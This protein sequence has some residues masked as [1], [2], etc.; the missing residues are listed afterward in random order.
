MPPAQEGPSSGRIRKPAVCREPR[1]SGA[2]T[3]EPGAF[4]LWGVLVIDRQALVAQVRAHEGCVLHAYRDS[5][6][7]LTI[8]IGRL[9]DPLVG[10]SISLDEAET[11]LDHDLDHAERDLAAALP[12]WPSLDECRQ[13]ALI[14]LAFNLGIVG[15]MRFRH[16]L[17][18]L[19]GR[20]YEAAALALL[21][22]KWA[23]QVGPRRAARIAGM[24]RE[25][26]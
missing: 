4:S 24:I 16:T 11:L 26:R 13:R 7:Y 2:E 23:G 5:R 21:D 19:E 14:E 15:L 22:S 17:A 12:W 3:L 25:G 10:G 1:N 6:G 20:D 8:G 18:L 9:I